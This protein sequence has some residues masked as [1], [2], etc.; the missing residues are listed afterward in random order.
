MQ[1][2][3]MIVK[4]IEHRIEMMET[5]SHAQPK[6]PPASSFVPVAGGVLQRKCG[7]GGS[8]GCSRRVRW[9]RQ[10]EALDPAFKSNL[11]IRN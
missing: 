7:C 8:A 10:S 4:R 9:L 1:S 11:G 2:L 5:R 3:E 6:A